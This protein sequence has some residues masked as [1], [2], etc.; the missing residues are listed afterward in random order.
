MVVDRRDRKV[1]LGSP[2]RL[3]AI[4]RTRELLKTL[5]VVPP[6]RVQILIG[7]GI[8]SNAVAPGQDLVITLFW[9]VKAAL[10]DD[11][12]VFVHLVGSQ[13][14]LTQADGVPLEGG[15]PTSLWAPGEVIAD[16][17]V[18][19][20]PTDAL[21]GDYELQVGFYQPSDGWRLPVADA[22][23]RLLPDGIASLPTKVE[24]MG[25]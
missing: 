15:Y 5:L 18:L 11:L 13:E 6:Q 24:V 2:I 12:A 17:R 16:R 8:E 19:R 25:P 7:I 14:V 22:A 9:E 3:V 23:G 20:I 21:A 4:R 1:R 10:A